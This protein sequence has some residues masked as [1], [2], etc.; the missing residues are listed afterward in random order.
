MHTSELEKSTYVQPAV[1]TDAE[2]ESGLAGVQEFVVAGAPTGGT[3]TLNYGGQT[4]S[5]LAF[6]AAASDVETALEA[7]STVG[8]GKVTVTGT[9][10]F[11]VTFDPSLTPATLTGDASA[12]TG[13]TDEQIG[14]VT[15]TEGIK[16]GAGDGG[17]FFQ[18]IE[19][20]KANVINGTLVQRF[21]PI[22]FPQK[23]IK[24]TGQ[25]ADGNPVPKPATSA[26]F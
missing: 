21:D 10:P 24:Y 3:Y 7:L 1:S 13:G 5:A 9:N 8:S 25:D 14:V 12:L 11:T 19:I 2:T 17:T 16:A 4:T 18:D 22:A 26:S 20:S 6:N 15:I 23:G